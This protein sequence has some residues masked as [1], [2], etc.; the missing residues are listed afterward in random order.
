MSDEYRVTPYKNVI[1]KPAGHYVF[2]EGSNWFARIRGLDGDIWE[3]ALEYMDDSDDRRRDP[4]GHFLSL[5]S[6]TKGA[7]SA[8]AKKEHSIY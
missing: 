2:R 5:D 7:K 1:G 4:V 6:A 3:V 8:L